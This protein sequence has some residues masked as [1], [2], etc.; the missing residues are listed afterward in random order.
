MSDGYNNRIVKLSMDGK[1]AGAFGSHGKLAGQFH[2]CHQLAAGPG[3]SIYTA[4]IL[5]WR[6][7]KFV[8]R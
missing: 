4:E 5:N 3:G 2:Y 7:Q 8:V 1:I 6:P